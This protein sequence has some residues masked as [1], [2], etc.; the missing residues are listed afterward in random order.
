MRLSNHGLRSLLKAGVTY[1]R[2]RRET[3]SRAIRS[4]RSGY[5]IP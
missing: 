4:G 2:P 3:L 5:Q 1:I